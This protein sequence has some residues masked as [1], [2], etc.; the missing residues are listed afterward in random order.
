MTDPPD[1]N[2]AEILTPLRGSFDQGNKE[3]VGVKRSGEEA[4]CAFRRE[5][6]LEPLR[7]RGNEDTAISR[8]LKDGR[9]G[10]LG[11]VW[12]FCE[13]SVHDLLVL[14]G[15]EGAGGVDDRPA[16]ANGA[17]SGMKD[18]SLTFGVPGEMLRAEPVANLRVAAQGAGSTAWHVGK[19]E[20][21]DGIR[22]E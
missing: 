15:L 10:M 22:I 11:C 14:L 16:W 4:Q 21:E 18:R 1:V 9:E 6:I 2:K 12:I 8:G 7:S 3:A 20:I 13:N 17:K 5:A 19:S